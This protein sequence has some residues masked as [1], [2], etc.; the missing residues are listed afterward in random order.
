MTPRQALTQEL[1]RIIADAESAK[2]LIN[3]DRRLTDD[4]FAE[5]DALLS[6]QRAYGLAVLL[7]HL[8]TATRSIEYH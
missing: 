1:D 7:V 8:Q 2:R 6:Y 5:F 3:L 4:C